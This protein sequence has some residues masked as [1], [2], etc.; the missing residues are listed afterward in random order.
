MKKFLLAL[1]ACSFLAVAVVS[2]GL[3][4]DG[5][6]LYNSKCQGCHGADGA[7]QVM[8]MTRHL[9]GMSEADALAALKGYKAKTFGGEKKAIMDGIAARLSDEEIQA[10]AQ[11]IGKF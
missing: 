3:A 9:K 1:A 11:H 4:A 10:L 2:S 5:A 6:A 8:G 7:K